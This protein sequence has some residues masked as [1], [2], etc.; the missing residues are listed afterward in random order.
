[1]LIPVLMAGTMRMNGLAEAQ[2]QFSGLGWFV[3]VLPTAF[4]I[5]LIATLAEGERAPFD[6]LEAES[7][8]VAGFNIEY[9][10]MKFAWFYL[11]FFLNSWVLV[12]SAPRCSWAAGKVPLSIRSGA[13]CGYFFAKTMAMFFLLA[14][15]RA[16]FPRLRIDQMMGFCWKFLVPLALALFMAVAIILKL[17]L[18]QPYEGIALLRGQSHAARDRAMGIGPGPTPASGHVQAV[19][20]T[21]NPSLVR[22]GRLWFC[23]ASLSWWR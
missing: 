14:W 7:E 21:R 5:F 4:L 6:L 16:T 2:G 17:D 12:P 3:W 9:S 8:I 22:T 18:P 13:G 19:V 15:I 20:R 10:G 1:M 11:A 23:K